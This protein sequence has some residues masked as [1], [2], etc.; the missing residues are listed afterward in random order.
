VSDLCLQKQIQFL[1][2]FPGR[3]FHFTEHITNMYYYQLVLLVHNWYQLSIGTITNWSR[4]TLIL[5]RLLF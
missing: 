5:E 1:V 3:E 4:L 2:S